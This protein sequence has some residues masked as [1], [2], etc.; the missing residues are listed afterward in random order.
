MS[1]NCICFKSDGVATLAR[2]AVTDGYAGDTC[3]TAADVCLTAAGITSQSDGCHRCAADADMTA[4]NYCYK[5]D[6]TTAAATKV[7]CDATTTEDCVC[8]SSSGLA[9]VATGETCTEA[10]C[11]VKKAVLHKDN[12]PLCADT[13]T[14]TTKHFCAA[15]TDADG[16]NTQIE[17]DA[18]SAA[19]PTAK[20]V[21]LKTAKMG[22]VKGS[23]DHCD[24]CAVEDGKVSAYKTEECEYCGATALGATKFCYRKDKTMT[25]L[26]ACADTTGAQ[27]EAAECACEGSD[28]VHYHVAKDG[29]CDAKKAGKSAGGGGGSGSSTNALLSGLAMGFVL[30]LKF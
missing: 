9:Y 15:T 25:A 23:G 5:K 28:K 1:T 18:C 6:A 10:I 3:T 14:A 27:K 2:A 8:R 16:N 11:D 4:T 21:C 17:M 29:M 12:C 19:A 7:L 24:G 26:A 22:S 13:T 30:L 20:C